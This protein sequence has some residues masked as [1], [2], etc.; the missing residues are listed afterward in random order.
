VYVPTRSI[1][2]DLSLGQGG[3]LQESKTDLLAREAYDGLTVVL[4]DRRVVSRSPVADRQKRKVVI[5]WNLVTEEMIGHRSGQI[6]LILW[7]PHVG[8][9]IE[10]LPAAEEKALG[11][12]RITYLK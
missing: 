2:H 5:V 10:I 6:H 9:K 3:T 4:K 8:S 12:C 7:H 1:V 11:G